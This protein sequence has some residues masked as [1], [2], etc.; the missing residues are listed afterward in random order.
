MS[1]GILSKP[2]YEALWKSSIWR[3]QL[4]SGFHLGKIWATN[5]H[6]GLDSLHVAE[7]QCGYPGSNKA[8]SVERDSVRKEQLLGTLPL[9]ERGL[10]P[11]V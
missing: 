10:H 9:F 4:V 11:A 5:L 2:P 8:I 6:F 3:I 1:P 7:G